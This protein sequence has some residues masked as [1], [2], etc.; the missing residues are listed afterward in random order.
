MVRGEIGSGYPTSTSVGNFTTVSWTAGPMHN[1]T[2]TKP[3]V[4]GVE[5]TVVVTAFNNGSQID[6][7]RRPPTAPVTVVIGGNGPAT[8]VEGPPVT[9]CAY[10]PTV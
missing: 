8:M 5:V 6:Y 2:G 7:Y 4:A 1:T 9:L 3:V 10:S